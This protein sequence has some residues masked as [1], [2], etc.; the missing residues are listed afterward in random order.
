MKAILTLIMVCAMLQ[1]PEPPKP[2][3]FPEGLYLQQETST[4]CTLCASTMMVRSAL[5]TRNCDG[6]ECIEEEDIATPAWCGDGLLWNW[7]YTRNGTTILVSHTQLQGTTEES[8]NQ[9]LRD[10]PE[11]I[12]L[13]CGGAV[14]HGVFLTRYADGVFYC[15]DPAVGYAGEEIPLEQS[16]LGTRLGKQSSIL[17]AATAYW[18]VDNET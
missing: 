4:S 17:S 16:L 8:L 15:A 14:Q 7:C 3:Q 13:Y 1:T 2:P 5:Y 11:G 10:H 12:V 18:Y 9:I 6:W